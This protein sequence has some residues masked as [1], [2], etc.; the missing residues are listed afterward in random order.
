MAFG[1]GAHRCMGSNIGRAEI[2]I[3]L[4]EVLKRLPDYEVEE[5]G[6]ELAP[7]VGTVYAYKSLPIRFTPGKRVA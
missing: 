2:R 1:I 4:E 6:L 7:D 3:C 5:A